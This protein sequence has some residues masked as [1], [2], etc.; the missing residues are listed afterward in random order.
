M[1]KELPAVTFS[2]DRGGDSSI[3][4]CIDGRKKCTGPS[5]SERRENG[6]ATETERKRD[7]GKDGKGERGECGPTRGGEGANEGSEE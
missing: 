4:G 6:K 1:L 5:Y 7:S 3:D 2:A